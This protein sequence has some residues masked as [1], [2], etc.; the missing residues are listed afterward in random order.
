MTYLPSLIK[1]IDDFVSL[2]ESLTRLKK[3]AAPPP[4]TWSMPDDPQED[5]E[6]LPG[7]EFSG[8]YPKVMDVINEI[9]S[10]ESNEDIA[11]ELQLIAE[12]Y[13]KAIEI[14]GGYKQVQDYIRR[15]MANIDML[16]DESDG[17][18]GDDVRDLADEVLEDLSGDLRQRAKSTVSP[19]IPEPQAL[20]A[21]K[22]VKDEFNSAEAR[23]EV[24]SQKSVYE[25]GKPGQ[26]TGHTIVRK[27]AETPAKYAKEIARLRESLQTAIDPASKNNVEY[28]IGTLV[29]LIEQM[30][31]VKRLE[32]ELKVSPGDSETVQAF[33]QATAKLEQ[34]RKQR[35]IYRRKLN[36]LILKDD[37]TQL[38]R[39]M[40]ESRD[41]QEKAWLDQQIKLLD[42]RM[43]A[44]LLRKRDL[45]K[46][47]KA[48]VHSL[49]TLDERED[50][51][52]H[53]LPDAD[54]IA[55]DRA[56][57]LGQDR[58][59]TKEKYDRDQ[60][61]ERAKGH[62]KIGPVPERRKGR[63]GGGREGEKIH[64][65]DIGQAT[66][67]G[68]VDKLREKIN[69]SAH[70]AR[71]NVTQE[72]LADKRKVHN[73]LKPYVDALSKA[74][75][76]KDNKAKY[77]AIKALKAQMAEWAARATAIKALSRNIRWLPFF[78][79][80]RENLE[81]IASWKTE[82][83]WD[84]NENKLTFIKNVMAGADRLIE[85]FG[86]YYEGKG[87]APKGLDISFVNT[88]KYLGDVV[89]QLEKEIQAA[90]SDVKYRVEAPAEAVEE[91]EEEATPSK[92]RMMQLEQALKG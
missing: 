62:G 87:G 83:G 12:L 82:A 18:I 17:V 35:L 4:E 29:E 9:N 34:L 37:Q 45:I 49:G 33:D 30:K 69:T 58:T 36:E 21:L 75:Q 89:E 7:D 15:A 43:D 28:L 5:D 31:T 59:V 27:T 32:G 65:Y 39:R 1:K 3:M 70:V 41:P 40:Y 14:N 19:Q 77:E 53:S 26:E 10:T 47:M 84:L 24:A 13:K 79:K 38:R 81:T 48:K 6:A 72:V 57:M 2:A 22:A 16:I 78:N 86:R 91:E 52:S 90:T 73:A 64:Q 63:V 68:L 88:V 23:K 50:F 66:F 8:L 55:L 11:N 60:T 67:V 20:Q 85:A 46:A 74:I 44:K 56:I 71:L 80:L 42:V 54:R 25:R 61:I 51:Q 92:Q 76:K